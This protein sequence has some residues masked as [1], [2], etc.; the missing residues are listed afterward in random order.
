M[1]II[2]K[3]TTLAIGFIVLIS[4]YIDMTSTA[5]LSDDGETQ[6]KE[7]KMDISNFA[8]ELNAALSH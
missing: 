8:Q 7:F 2:I 4:L 6:F 5:N 3:L 1:K